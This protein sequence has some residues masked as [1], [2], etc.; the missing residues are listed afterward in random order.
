MALRQA[1]LSMFL[2][3]GGLLL[4]QE[5]PA[6]TTQPG[7]SNTVVAHIRLE[8]QAITPATVRFIRRGMREAVDAR[9]ECVVIELNTPGGLLQ[10]TQ[11]LVVDILGSSVPV[12]VYVS[13]SGAR[14][15]SAGVFITLASQLYSRPLRFVP[16][17]R[18]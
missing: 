2:L 1:C 18:F 6:E 7:N 15:A 17:F 5:H 12:V 3:V 13:P 4:G 14:A 11:E 10:S 9:A 8:D 16:V